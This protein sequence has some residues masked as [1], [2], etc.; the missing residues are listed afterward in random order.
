M[1]S[2]FV[3]LSSPI[4]MNKILTLL[5]FALLC[6]WLHSQDFNLSFETT[7]T[8]GLPS[9]WFIQYPLP[10]SALVDDAHNGKKA[11]SI[12]N[13]Y[14]YFASNLFLGDIA[15]QKTS[16][17]TDLGAQGSFGL[18]IGQKI[19]SLKG[20]YKYEKIQQSRLRIDSGQV[21]VFLRRFVASEQKSI[22]VGQGLLNL[23]KAEQYTEFTVPIHYLKDL[24]PDTISIFFT[25][26]SGY[27]ALNPEG[28][29]K[30]LS[31]NNPSACGNEFGSTCLYLTIDDLS[32][33]FTTPTKNLHPNLQPLQISPNPANDQAVIS[34]ELRASSRN[35]ELSISD[36]LG[37]TLRRIQTDQ[38]RVEVNTNDLPRGMYMVHLR[39]NGQ[40]LGVERL[41]I[42]H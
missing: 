19:K 13:T 6:N 12:S 10:K 30:T 8:S 35:V 11:I 40:L 21:I 26:A 42:T 18:P 20:W 17:L 39:Q 28:G 36:V 14:S 16:T 3:P 33:Q 15:R 41:L 22:I 9:N 23:G 2:I 1:I 37:R 5:L 24:T 25:T 32:L 31:F 38:N 4:P 27:R 29:I 34:W 7:D